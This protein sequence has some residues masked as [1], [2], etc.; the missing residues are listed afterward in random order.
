MGKPATPQAPDPYQTAG[1]QTGANQ[2]NAAYL[3]ALN[4]MNTYGP[5][6]SQT[7]KNEGADPTTGAPI[8]SSSTTLSPEQQAL[9]N[10]NTSNQ[11]NQSG[12]AG[13][14]LDQARSAYQ[15]INT[16]WDQQQ[17]KSQDALYGRNT[18]YLDPQFARQEKGLDAKLAAQGITPGSEAW[19]NAMDEFGAGKNQAYEAARDNSITGA[20]QQTG[21]NI[22][23]S[24]ALQNQPLNY[25]N[26]LMSGNQAQ[27]PQFSQ[28]SPINTNPADVQGAINQNYQG[29]VNA[30]NANVGS[31][32]NTTSTLGSLLAMYLMSDERLKDD[33]GVIGETYEGIPI[34]SYNYKG[35]NTPQI[36]VMAQDVEKVIPEAVATHPSGY[37]MVNYQ[38]VR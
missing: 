1:A 20:S 31:S 25:Y 15:P 30:Y 7:Y 9:Y 14:A 13:N 33:H 19:K 35:S 22:Q 36:G 4:R 21:Q 38:L 10:S 2:Q 27:V 28:A 34:H 16:N 5:T 29:N 12:F 3:A 17:Q 8:Y 24:I 6:G 26:S 11:L 18:R 23:Q 37:K 32:N